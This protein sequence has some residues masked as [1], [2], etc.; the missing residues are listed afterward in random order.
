M[1]ELGL[2]MLIGLIGCG[3]WCWWRGSEVFMPTMMCAVTLM[4]LMMLMTA[5]MRFRTFYVCHPVGGG[6]ESS[7]RNFVCNKPDKAENEEG[8]RSLFSH[9]REFLQSLRRHYD[10]LRRDCRNSLSWENKDL[11]VVHEELGSSPF[12]QSQTPS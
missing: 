6:H 2:L 4:T 10:D 5:R 1:L 3:R 11:F 12:S 7:G 9:E 8:K